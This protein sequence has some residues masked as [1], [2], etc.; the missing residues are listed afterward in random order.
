MGKPVN[1]LGLIRILPPRR[2]Y[3]AAYSAGDARSRWQKNDTCVGVDTSDP[4]DGIARN[5]N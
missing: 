5:N 1:T 3:P 4:S 2:F